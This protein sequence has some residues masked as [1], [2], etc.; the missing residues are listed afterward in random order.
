MGRSD[1]L[2]AGLKA[3][4]SHSDIE[5]VRAVGAGD[6]MLDTHC[7]RPSLLEGFHLRSS[8]ECRLSDDFSDGSV[9]FRF[10][11][12]VLSVEVD[13]RYLHEGIEVLGNRNSEESECGAASESSALRLLRPR[14]LAQAVA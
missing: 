8:D 14:L 1:H 7:L 5:G 2:V 4:C 11:A 13:K 12:Q 10:D 9:N 6:A 3:Q